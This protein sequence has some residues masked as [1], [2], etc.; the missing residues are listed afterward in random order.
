MEEYSPGWRLPARPGGWG[1]GW[2]ATGPVPDLVRGAARGGARPAAE[3]RSY[4]PGVVCRSPRG[5]GAC[6]GGHLA[7]P[8]HSCRARAVGCSA[9]SSAGRG[10]RGC[11]GPP[12]GDG[13]PPPAGA[14]RAGGSRAVES[15]RL[16]LAC[17][18]AGEPLRK[19]LSRSWLDGRTRRVTLPGQVDGPEKKMES[20]YVNIKSLAD[21]GLSRRLLSS[22]YVQLNG[23]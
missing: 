14:G 9:V 23:R 11:R 10:W 18:W 12:G 19:I 7:W 17:G 4:S 13:S 6:W 1:G 20:G 21:N 5:R 22:V 3:G 16:R 15:P 2:A 8:R